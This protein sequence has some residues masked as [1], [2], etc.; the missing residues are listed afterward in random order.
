MRKENLFTDERNT[1][2]DYSDFAVVLSWPDT[3]ARADDRWYL[4]LKKIGVIRNLNFRVGHAAIILVDS[5]SGVALYYDFGRYVTPRG[6]GRARSVL[7]DP[8]LILKTQCTF[9][10]DA[11]GEPCITNIDELIH[12]LESKKVDTHG[13][14]D[15]YYSVAPY[16]SFSRART[17]ADFHCLRGSVRYSAFA[18][19]NNNCSRFVEQVLVAGLQEGSVTRWQVDFPETFVASPI[20]NVINA[21][22]D[23]QLTKFSN[24][25]SIHFR[26]GRLQSLLFFLSKVAVNFLGSKS[27]VVPADVNAGHTDCPLY[28]P[29]NIPQNAQWLGGI[30][31]G[32][33]HVLLQETPPYYKLQK[34]N[35]DGN[36]EYE[37][38]VELKETDSFDYG[39]PYQFD[40]DTHAMQATLVQN[41]N[42]IILESVTQEK[43]NSD[44]HINS[45]S[46]YES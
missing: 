40:F 42:R 24:G 32:G 38:V 27:V 5:S 8:K 21:R 30:G 19:G 22:V 29:T 7:T 44:H 41:S 25:K 1:F 31:E 6:M 11:N 16:V 3:T 20:S 26:M 28:S 12:E 34:F 33:W 18:P 39:Q 14:G 17:S 45:T 4:W 10:F 36:L 43:F 46:H 37:T 23:H 15:L 35:I 13:N 9:G 2:S